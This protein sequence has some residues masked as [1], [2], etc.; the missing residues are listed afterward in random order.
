MSSN[1]NN[2]TE[3]ITIPMDI[4]ST[5]STET[6]TEDDKNEEYSITDFKEEF[7]YRKHDL[8]INVKL[9]KQDLDNMECKYVGNLKLHFQ[10]GQSGRWKLHQI[11]IFRLRDETF[12][13]DKTISIK[14]SESIFQEYEFTFPESQKS[15]KCYGVAEIE[16]SLSGEKFYLRTYATS[17]IL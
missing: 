8:S 3:N 4:E 14:K 5:S 11:G 6:G 16:D 7:P 1:E 9:Q 10:K 17:K 15:E 2:K 12:H 13:Y